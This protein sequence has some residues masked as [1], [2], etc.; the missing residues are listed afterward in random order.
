MD[1]EE[2][3]LWRAYRDEPSAEL[4]E[5]LILRYAPLVKY[6]AGRMAVGMPSHVDRRDLASYGMF[7]L[8][9]AID[10]FDVDSGYKFETYASRR[11][12]GAI[13]DELR[14]MDWVPRSV[15]RKAREIERALTELQGR[16]H[17]APTDDELAK[18]LDLTPEQLADALTQVSM[19]SLA[20]LD[21]ALTGADGDTISIID[22]V[23][24]EGQVTPDEAVDERAMRQLVSEAME[25]LTDREQTVLALYYF[26][27]MTLRQVGEVLGVTESR[28]CQ[29]HSKAILA[30]RSRLERDVRG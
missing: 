30:L 20:A 7:G 27:G 12:R 22:T 17:R 3:R 19:T 6:V 24:D 13:V 5:R 23:V 14:S 16:L 26:D 10:R 8:L 28:V 11:V 21:S 29:I 25:R 4:R 18:E 1:P 15:R 9:D 2:L